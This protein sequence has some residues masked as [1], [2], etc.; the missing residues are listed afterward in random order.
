[1]IPRIRSVKPMPNY[2]LEIAFDDGKLVCY[3]V[4][5]DMN[6]PNYGM[7]RDIPGLFQQIRLDES[8]TVVYW[9]DEIDLPSD[10]LYQ[11]GAPQETRLDA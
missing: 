10:I 2:R 3:D 1:M 7:L 5:E 9:N 4:K 8:R 11:Y 6:L